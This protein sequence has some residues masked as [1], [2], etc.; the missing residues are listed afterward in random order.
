MSRHFAALAA[1][2]S[3]AFVGDIQRSWLV[4]VDAERDNLRAALE[5]A[6]DCDDVNTAM[7][8]AGGAAFPHWLSGTPVEGLR[9]ID[10]AFACGRDPSRTVRALGL[11]GRG[12]LRFQNG[13]RDGVDDDLVAAIALHQEL[14]DVA[15]LAMSYSFWAEVSAVRGDPDEARRRRA[16]ILAFYEL[17]PDDDLVCGVRAFSKAKIAALAGDLAESEAQYRDAL[18]HFARIDRPV[19]TAMT[20][21]MVSD[22]DERAGRYEAAAALLQQAI[23]LGDALGL[24]GFTS[25]QVARLARALLESGHLER[26]ATLYERTLET[27][28]RMRND[29]VE[30]LALTGLAELARQG[31]DLAGAA[32]MATRA[33]AVH[34]AAGPARLANRVTPQTETDAALAMCHAVLAEAEEAVQFGR[35]RH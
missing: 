9:W 11:T 34:H 33:I 3:L 10:A 19:M 31:G 30:F 27:A 14:G 16:E 23:D 32:S 17:L 20:A 4:T 2:S 8:I 35:E 22:F 15:A 7:T 25:A 21:S 12:L 13:I 5:W 24:R 26:A 18:A 28:Q 1:Q 6:L 29:R